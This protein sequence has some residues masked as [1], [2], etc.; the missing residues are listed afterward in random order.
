M[1]HFFFTLFIA[2][3]LVGCDIRKSD[4]IDTQTLNETAL[5][6]PTSVQVIDSV[7]NFG[8]IKEGELILFN[9]RFKNTGT[10]P[11]VIID[12]KASC[13]CTI[14]EKPEQPI[15]PGEIGYIK[16]R[17]NSEHK[18]GEAHKAISITSNASPE[19]PELLLKGT[20]IGKTEEE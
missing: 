1:K 15:M 13:G 4:K 11:L 3:A 14:A 18:P 2:I 5:K 8:T 19:F 6:A 20:V 10:N 16:A 12:A 9:F 17:F 7:H